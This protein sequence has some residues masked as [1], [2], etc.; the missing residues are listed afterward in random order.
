MESGTEKVYSR[1]SSLRRGFKRLWLRI[2][3]CKSVEDFLSLLFQLEH[4]LNSQLYSPK[5]IHRIIFPHFHLKSHYP[6]LIS[7]SRGKFPSQLM[8]HILYH[9]VLINSP[10]DRLRCSELS[11][12]NLFLY[13]VNFKKKPIYIIYILST[14]RNRSNDFASSDFFIYVFIKFKIHYLRP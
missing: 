13:T 5:E 8:Q 2:S 1:E 9:A 10:Y 4:L 11:H 3:R 6:T 12:G 7:H 14:F